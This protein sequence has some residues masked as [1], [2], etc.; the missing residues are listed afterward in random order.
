MQ[1][2]TVFR[3]GNSDV[4][5]LAPAVKKKTGIKTGSKVVVQVSSD[6]KTIIINNTDAIRKTNFLSPDFFEWM[7]K[8]NQEYGVALSELA[9]K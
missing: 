7:E 8:F 9:K 6:G 4:V 5:A 1:L 3:A 2:Q